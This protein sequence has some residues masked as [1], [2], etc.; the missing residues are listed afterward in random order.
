MPNFTKNPI[1]E[2]VVKKK[3]VFR[4]MI[5][6]EYV[7]TVTKKRPKPKNRLLIKNPQFLSIRPE[8]QAILPTHELVILTKFCSYRAKIVNFSSVL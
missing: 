2:N 8:I 1:P 6:V 3:L 7:E 4:I 5:K